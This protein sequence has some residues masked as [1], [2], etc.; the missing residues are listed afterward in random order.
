Y[1][2]QDQICIDELV[3]LA[4]LTVMDNCSVDVFVDISP[5]GQG[6]SVEVKS[7]TERFSGTLTTHARGRATRLMVDDNV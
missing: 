4:P 2:V 6:V 7:M 3:F 1:F 5:N